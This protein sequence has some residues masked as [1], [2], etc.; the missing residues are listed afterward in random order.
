M[1]ESNSKRTASEIEDEVARSEFFVYTNETKIAD[2]PK[3]TLTHL[4]VDSSVREIP[5]KAFVGCRA[6]VQ[7]QLP[8]TTLAKI[9]KAAFRFCLKLKWIQFLSSSSDGKSYSPINPNLVVDD[10]LIVFPE[11]SGI[12][13]ID[14]GAFSHCNRLRKVI[15]CSVST[16]LGEGAF[17]GCRGLICVD[18]P[19]GLQMIERRLFSYCESLTTVK[20]PSSVIAIGSGAFCQ[21]QSLTSVKLPHGLI[22]LGENSFAGCCSIETLRI[23]STVLSIGKSAFRD[24]CSLKCIQLPTTLKRIE[25]CTFLRCER[26][27]YIEIPSTVVFIGMEAFGNCCSLSHIRVPPSVDCT[28]SLTSIGGCKNLISIELPEG[29]LINNSQHE[30]HFDGMSDCS[31]LVNMA[32]PTL[33]EDFV[34]C[35]MRN[36]KFDSVVE[37]EADLVRKIKHRFDNSPLN[38]LCYYQSYYSSNDA[39]VQLRSLM[40]KEPS[41][42]TSKVDEFGMTPLHILSLSKIPNMDMLVA[43]LKGG[44]KDDLFHCKDS[45]GSAPMDYLC[46]NRMPSATQGI[47]R[48]VQTRLYMLLGLERWKVEMLQAVDEALAVDWSSRR[49]SI[50][51]IYFKIANYERKESLSLIELFLWKMKIEGACSQEKYDDRESCRIT[52]GACTVIPHLLPFLGDIDMEDYVVSAP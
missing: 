40:E 47:R 5:E 9:G 18:L 41:S 1:E 26:L 32:I 46:L 7:V 31:S 4:R 28:M 42:A 39:M 13:Q 45:F 17:F 6:L 16:R 15:V 23:P 21:C 11:R 8:D 29:L 43:V 14:D 51:M 20:I 37:D 27:E 34:G 25:T 24:C 19:A 22:E 12:L 30:G 33:T 35:F 48:L 52:S 3:A 10:G 49:S 36:L 38:K 2:I 50:G 44:H